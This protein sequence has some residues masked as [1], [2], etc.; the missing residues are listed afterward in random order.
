AAI[1]E[2]INKLPDYLNPGGQAFI[3]FDPRQ[4]EPIKK[5]AQESGLRCEIKKDS[6][7]FDR[8]IHLF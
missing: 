5:L 3:E 1:S 6:A 8:I 2:I 7:D 4:T